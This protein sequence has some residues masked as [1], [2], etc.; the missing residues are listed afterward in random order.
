MRK[1][2]RGHTALIAAR[3][4]GHTEVV[5]ILQEAGAKE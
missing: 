3:L 2:D 1:G 5:R 4:N